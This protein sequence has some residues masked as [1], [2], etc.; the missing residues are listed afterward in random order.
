[1]CSYLTA[2]TEHR[3]PPHCLHFHMFQPNDSLETRSVTNGLVSRPKLREVVQEE[4]HPLSAFGVSDR[5]KMASK[6]EEKSPAEAPVLD[7]V[8]DKISG[9]AA[10]KAIRKMFLELR[11]AVTKDEVPDNLFSKEVLTQETFELSTNVG[12]SGLEKGRKILFEIQHLVR[13]NPEKFETFCEVLEEH[14]HG[15]KD[16]IKKLRGKSGTALFS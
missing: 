8:L 9:E 7:L 13:Y 6:T 11:R 16:L 14:G 5:S 3:Q 2:K 1:M 10:D 4:I 12:L 15:A